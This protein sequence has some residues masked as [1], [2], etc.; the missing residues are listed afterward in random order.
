MESGHQ[1]RTRAS[2]GGGSGWVE[3]QICTGKIRKPNL[4]AKPAAAMQIFTWSRPNRRKNA[5][6]GNWS[7][8]TELATGEIS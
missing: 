1:N 5:S 3:N 4:R 2:T 7:L 6:R 8:A